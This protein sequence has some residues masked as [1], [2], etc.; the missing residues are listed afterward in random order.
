[1]DAA[2]PHTL[3]QEQSASTISSG[4]PGKEEDNFAAVLVSF[5][6]IVQADGVAHGAARGCAAWNIT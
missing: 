3:L 6:R 5:R 2:Q 4:A 1:M